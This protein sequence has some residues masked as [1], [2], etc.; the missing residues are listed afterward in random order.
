MLSEN[1]AISLNMISKSFDF[2]KLYSIVNRISFFRC[3]TN[4]N[5]IWTQ[6]AKVYKNVEKLISI[7]FE[8]NYVTAH[9]NVKKL[10]SIKFKHNH[11]TIHKKIHIQK[12]L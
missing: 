1:F 11:T 12:K 4:V 5:K 6:S 9:K 3:E 10:M 7:K 8:Q 2:L